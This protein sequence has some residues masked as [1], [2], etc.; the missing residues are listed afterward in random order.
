MKPT[1]QHY[2]LYNNPYEDVLAHDWHCQHLRNVSNHYQS[3]LV[4]NINN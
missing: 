3:H 1:S 4:L 2:R